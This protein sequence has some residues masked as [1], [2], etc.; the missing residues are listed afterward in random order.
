MSIS[1]NDFIHKQHIG[2]Q[3]TTFRD[4]CEIGKYSFII[5]ADI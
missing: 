3:L 5:K 1:D 4:H 2:M